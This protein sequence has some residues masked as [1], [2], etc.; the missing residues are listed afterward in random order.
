MSIDKEYV[1]RNEIHRDTENGQFAP[2][3]NG[4]KTKIP[5]PNT[6]SLLGFQNK[7]TKED[8][9]RVATD[10]YQQALTDEDAS[11]EEGR[12]RKQVL[13]HE[14]YRIV[15]G[16]QLAGVAMENS[17]RDEIGIYVES[18]EQMIGLEPS[19]ES[20]Q[21]RSA[22]VGARSQ[23]G[24]T[25]LTV[26]SLRKYM[27]LATEGNPSL[28]APLFAPESLI[29]KESLMAKELR[30]LAPVIVS[31]R[32]GWKHLGYLQ[33]QRERMVGDGQRRRV[34]NRPELVEKFG[35]DV[36]YAAHALRL[37]LQG[38]EILETGRLALP[39]TQENIALVKS[40]RCGEVDFQE[41]LTRIDQVRDRLRDTLEN[42]QYDLPL[43]PDYSLINKWMV[44]AVT[45]YW[46]ETEG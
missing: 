28:L 34:P 23:A 26:Y 21:I 1:G 39:M 17:D 16:S 10:A 22:A 41:A 4:G 20:C 40:V 5:T 7:D 25:D 43:T 42:K 31:A 15:A 14:F 8:S 9:L 44:S 46:K 3:N 38:I 32:A 12:V 36:K 11:R 29:I 33:G 24:D 27:K 2:K 45:R 19:T 37:G 13:A 35:Y 18:L 6:A 30:E